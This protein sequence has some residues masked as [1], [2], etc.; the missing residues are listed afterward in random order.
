MI[1]IKRQKLF[2]NSKFVDTTRS[3]YYIYGH[4]ADEIIFADLLAL[5]KTGRTRCYTS[6]SAIAERPR[7]KAG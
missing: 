3:S 1:D 6:S 4:W 7:C 5:L 2:L